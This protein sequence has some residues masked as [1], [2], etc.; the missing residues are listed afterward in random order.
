MSNSVAVVAYAF[1]ILTVFL[2]N[3]DRG[4]R[5]SPG[6]WIPVAWLSICASRSVAQSLGGVDP[7]VPLETVFVE[8]NPLDALVFPTLIGGARLVLRTRSSR[9]ITF[10]RD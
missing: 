6:L 4:S 8:G 2:L 1:L 7:D 9:A 5:V 3:R 10:L